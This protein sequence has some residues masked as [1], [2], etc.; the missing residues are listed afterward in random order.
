[1]SLQEP[2]S[3]RGRWCIA[4]I[5]LCTALFGVLGFSGCSKQ[6]T[7]NPDLIILHTGRMRGN[8]YPLALQSIASLQH[9]Q[10]IS[11][12]VKQVREEAKQTGAKVLVVDMGDSLAGS[13]A[14]HVTESENMVT[15]FNDV[16]YDALFL[17][18][19]DYEIQ[20]STLAKLK[21][22]V[23]NPFQAAD[24][25]PATAGTT[26]GARID[27]DKLPVFLLANFYGDMDSQQFPER[28]P[29]WFGTTPGKVSPV[30]Q[31]EK[32][33]DEL[34]ARPTGSLTILSWMKFESPKNPPE[35][36]LA[37]LNKLGVQ[38]ILAHRIYGG[39]EKDVWVDS[40]FHDWKP[41]VSLNILRNN[42]GF[43]LARLDLKRDGE[44]WKV[45]GH[46]LLPMTANTVPADQGIIKAISKFEKPIQA[47]DAEVL[48]L[49]EPLD[50]AK[51][52]QVYMGSLA[53][54][55]GTQAVV[56]SPQSIRARWSTGELR[57]GQIFNSLPWT[58]PLVQLS[59]TKEQLQT[60]MQNKALAV[61]LQDG[62]PDGP[63]IV[64]TSKYFAALLS[65]RLELS[66]DSIR[67]TAIP[68]EFDYFVNYLKTTGDALTAQAPPAGWSVG[69]KGE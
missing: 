51:I 10:Y 19:L 63:I 31:Y 4:A 5:A 6:T 13:F 56:Y 28:F 44:G 7:D 42:G 64:T 17:S 34:G 3:G 36:F 55:P 60:V 26:F 61:W 40:G 41:P 21:A 15:F 23:I 35:S 69:N 16:G 9:Y 33:L 54:V 67:E 52:L 49:S 24:G 58:T 12:Y 32:T 38:M 46:K 59:L 53:K 14:S 11:A 62:L 1:M 18:N 27:L 29:A 66:T 2:R 57:A 43:A 8:V 39:N 45:L 68:S 37:S 30:R 65:A 50:A 48:K 20:P 25:Q 47:A 22:K